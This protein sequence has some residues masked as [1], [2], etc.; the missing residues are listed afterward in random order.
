MEI[1]FVLAAFWALAGKLQGFKQLVG[2][3]TTH[4]QTYAQVKLD[5]LPGFWVKIEII[6]NNHLEN[7][8]ISSI[9]T[10]ENE[11]LGLKTSIFGFHVNFAGCNAY[12]PG[13][14]AA[15]KLLIPKLMVGTL[16]FMIR[17]F[18]S[19]ISLY[20]YICIHIHYLSPIF[21]QQPIPFHIPRV[22]YFRVSLAELKILC[23]GWV[24]KTLSSHS[25]NVQREIR[26]ND[27]YVAIVTNEDLWVF[28]KIGGP[29]N[30]RW[31]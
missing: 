10:L 9:Y 22:F 2:G 17:N 31:K 27:P 28:P 14:L 19:C 6:W 3:W 13:M 23:P 29:Q 18:I 20:I 26:W 4:L 1:V 25:W 16:D 12:I 8:Y 5:H 24:L 21:L 11:Q 7:W 15:S 30:G